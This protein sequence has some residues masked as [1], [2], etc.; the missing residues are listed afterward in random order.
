M[1]VAAGA[2]GCEPPPKASQHPPAGAVATGAAA[3]VS[4]SASPTTAASA[5]AQAPSGVETAGGQGNP[6]K[7]DAPPAGEPVGADKGPRC[8]PTVD[9]PDPPGALAWI[10]GCAIKI[11]KPI[12]FPPD[13]YTI[14]PASFPVLDAV[15]E[16][17][18]RESALRVEIRGHT[19]PPNGP[20]YGM[21]LSQRR[22][23]S[24]A[25]Y[26][27]ENG[28]EQGRLVRKG[29]GEDMP[30]ASNKTEE[31]RR[32]NRRIEFIIIEAR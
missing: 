24:V 1:I 22:A 13:K 16:I 14:L 2:L 19:D 18:R 27:I 8:P 23:D 6:I 31:G 9:A 26:L 3:A 11:A 4:A 15:V 32:A 21:N 30:I 29:Y 28:I 7:L 5:Q 25:R 20:K 12:L 10:S 17:L